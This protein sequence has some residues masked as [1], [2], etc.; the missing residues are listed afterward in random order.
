MGS[1]RAGPKPAGGRSGAERRT[2]ARGSGGFGLPGLGDA[3]RGGPG[4]PAHRLVR[5]MHVAARR[6]RAGVS[7]R[8]H[9]LELV[10]ARVGEEAR[11]R[12]PVELHPKL[13][14]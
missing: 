8:L 3:I 9:D 13:T 6:D 11:I 5:E 2:R 12:M 10:A 14:H 7:Q 1:A 4:G